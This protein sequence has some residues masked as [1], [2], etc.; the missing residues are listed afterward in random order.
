VH[1]PDKPRRGA[2]VFQGKAAED[3]YS[4]SAG[5]IL[6]TSHG[7]RERF[8]NQ[9]CLV[10]RALTNTLDFIGECVG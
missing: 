6:Q 3:G 4:S 7:F 5:T 8:Q 1:I 2:S 9:I 10:L